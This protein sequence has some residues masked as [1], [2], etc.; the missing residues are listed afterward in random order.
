MA[1]TGAQGWGV[2]DAYALTLPLVNMPKAQRPLWDGRH[3]LGARGCAGGGAGVEAV[4][5]L[6][7][8][9]TAARCTT[10]VERSPSPLRLAVAAAVVYRELNLYLLNML[11]HPSA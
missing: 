11:C 5:G 6:Q 10:I 7:G 2:W 1:A 8:C 3:F 4:E 9:C